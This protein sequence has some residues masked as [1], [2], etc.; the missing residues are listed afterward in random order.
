MTSPEESSPSGAELRAGRAAVTSAPGTGSEL[1]RRLAAVTDSF[2]E[3]L[4]A[5]RL[6]AGWALVAT[7]GYGGGLLCPGSDIDV[8]LL[9]PPKA[10]GSEVAAVAESLWYPAWDAGVA[11]APS[12]QSV[13]SVA[14]LCRD[15]LPSATAFLRVRLLAGEQR[16]ADAAAAAALAAWRRKPADSLQRLRDASQQRAAAAGDVASLLEPNL[17]DGRGGLRDADAIAWASLAV[18]A[19]VAEAA[20]D[21]SVDELAG[22]VAVLVDVRWHLHLTTGRRSDVLLLQEQ[23]AVAAAIATGRGDAAVENAAAAGSVVDGATDRGAGTPFD[24][25]AL[26]RRVSAAARTIEWASER[27]WMRIDRALDPPRWPGQHAP[28]LDGAPPGVGVIGDEIV[29]HGRADL[30]DPALALDVAATAARSDALLSRAALTALAEDGA[31]PPMS[32]DERLRRAFVDLLGSAPG[33]IAAVETIERFGLFSRYL[34]EWEAVRDLPQRNA[35]HRYNVDRHLLV[36]VANAAAGDHPVRRRDL[37]LLGALLHDLG[38]GRDE[39]HSAV[40]MRLAVDVGRRMGLDEDDIA[41]LVMLVEHHLLLS[42]VATTRDL[43][44][45]RTIVNVA[46]AV[47]TSERLHLLRAL[48]EADSLATGPSAWSGWKRSLIDTL[49]VRVDDVLAGQPLPAGPDVEARYAELIAAVRTD[50]RPVARYG[51]GEL[52]VC[53]PDRKRLFRTVAAVLFTRRLDVVAADVWTLDDKVAIERFDVVSD[54]GDDVSAER[55]TRQLVDAIVDRADL[56]AAVQSRIAAL[57]HRRGRR[58]EAAAPPRTEVVITNRDSETATMI[59]VCAPDQPALLYR[60]ATVLAERRL[61]IRTARIATLGHEVLDVF[62]VEHRP[63]G[64]TA[65]GQLA[66]SEH[67]MLRDALLA[68]LSRSL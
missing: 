7:G 29:L 9:H 12:V 48:T 61:G 63:P 4:A 6:P 15:D 41:T 51:D 21:V 37:L 60:L 64:A 68:E 54:V 46:T 22:A 56:D 49:V 38:K 62:Y 32:W 33:M 44:D 24:A 14:R 50:E 5:D 11:L 25:D 42:E 17:K 35:F 27:F 20:L 2:W 65:W 52:V 31:R 47:G 34:P 19:D 1:A 55:L 58:L 30:D 66:E 43:D 40:G 45:E 39:D 67:P 59:E 18:G 26:M 10:G 53:A 28:S 16:L 57:E 8:A 3:R 36:T 23:D 13:K